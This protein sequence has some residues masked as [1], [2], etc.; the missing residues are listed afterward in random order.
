MSLPEITLSNSTEPYSITSGPD[1]NIWYVVP[2]DATLPG[3]INQV[4]PATRTVTQ[5]LTIPNSVVSIPNPVGITS[6][7]DGN[8]WFT[9]GGGAVGVVNLTAAVTITPPTIA[10]ES[11][12]RITKFNR[13]HKPV[14]KP[15]LSGYTITFSTDMDPS[16]LANQANYQVALMV[17]KKQRVKVGKK[18]VTKRVT[19]LQP[20]GFTVGNVTTNSVTLTLDGKQKFPNGGQITVIATP[21]SGVDS[22]DHVFLGQNGIL[23][24]SRGGT[25]I[26]LVS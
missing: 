13:K 8:L 2:G 5:T 16:A 9:D 17:P 6:G 15:I 22:E 24:I 12:V 18:T 10:S 11:V 26:T 25:G 1:G 23:A 3:T 4:N 20:I 14:G 19:V 21:P 7:P